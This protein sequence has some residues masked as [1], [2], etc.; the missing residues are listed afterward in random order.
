M[1]ENKTRP[2]AVTVSSF[3][4]KVGNP[5]IRKECVSII[6]L[7][8]SVSKQKPVM[9]GS[10]I[11]GFGKRHYVY[12]SGRE[13]DTMITGFSPRKQAIVLYLTGGLEPLREELAK[14]GKHTTG[15]GCLSIKT[16]K[17]VDL[18]VLTRILKK[19]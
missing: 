6:A 17:D 13:G 2:T 19:S 8:E 5:E 18:A 9:W 15:K 10:A 16:L 14:L 4:K 12:D 7:M 11:I 1:S 3:L